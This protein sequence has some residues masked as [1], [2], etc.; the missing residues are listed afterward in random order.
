MRPQPRARIGD[1]VEQGGTS[2]GNRAATT[3]PYLHH[4][5]G[6]VRPGSTR[7]RILIHAGRM[8]RVRKLPPAPRHTLCPLQNAPGCKVPRY[9]PMQECPPGSLCITVGLVMGS[10]SPLASGT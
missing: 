8:L 5:H 6:D 2:P 1:A 3:H 7:I 9:K 10:C 4:E